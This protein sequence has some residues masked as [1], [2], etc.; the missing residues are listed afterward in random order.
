MRPVLVLSLLLLFFFFFLGGLQDP[1]ERVR[2][3]AGPKRSHAV[4]G[5]HAV[6]RARGELTNF[7]R[8]THTHT[9]THTNPETHTHTHTHTHTRNI[10]MHTYT[11]THTHT[12]EGRPLRELQSFP[13]RTCL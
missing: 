10:H 9:H 12:H 1:H 13:H 7:Y 11:H 4:P 2:P 6:P 3:R 5:E 8:R